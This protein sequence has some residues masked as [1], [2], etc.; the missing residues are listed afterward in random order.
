MPL[1]SYHLRHAM[2]E[3]LPALYRV[4][5]K[6]GDSGRD[7]SAIQ[8]DPDIL[9]EI[10]VGPYVMLEPELAFALDG[11]RGPIGYLLGALNTARFNERVER[12]WL[13]RLQKSHHDPGGNPAG[14]RGSDW[15]RHVVH[16][17]F[18][19]V[20]PVLAPYPSHAH[21]DLLVE[22]RG[23]GIGRH[24]MQTMMERLT[25]LGSPGLHL[26]VSPKNEAAQDFYQGLGFAALSSPDLPEDTLFMACSLEDIHGAH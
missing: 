2:P 6:T 22:A 24:L 3:D 15:V 17:P 18:L 14:W 5:L 16:H 25:E 4:C 21:I 11:P 12:E 7:A 10:Y 19:K 8:D 1:E 13:P 23:Q 9:G 26:Q 20:P